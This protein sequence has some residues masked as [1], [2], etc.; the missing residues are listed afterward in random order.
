VTA[1][2]VV[3]GMT[4]YNNARHL[5][6]AADS[7]LAQTR[8]DFVLLMLDDGSADE[9]EVIAREYERRDARVRYIRH[10]ARCGMV[11][12]WRE[13]A[14]IAVRD[15]PEAPYFAWTSDHDRWHPEWLARLAA[16]L[17]AHPDVVLTYPHSP[18]I[19]E[20]GNPGAKE[21]REFDTVG[22]P[23]AA[24]RWRHF[25]HEGVG[26]GDMVYGLVRARALQAAGIFR[27]VLRP[28]RLLLAELTL[29]GHIQQVAEPLWFRRQAG[30]ASI[31]R[32]SRTLFAGAAPR[33]F[34]LPPWIQHAIVMLREYRGDRAPLRIPLGRLLGMVAL[35]QATYA[36]R[37][38][39]KSDTSHAIGRGVGNVIWSWKVAKRTY[40]H[41]VYYTLVEGRRVWGLARRHARRVTYEVLMAAHAARGRLRRLGRSVLHELLVLTHRLGLRG[42]T[43]TR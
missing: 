30:V 14:E 18:R 29:Q 16:V 34:W 39:R 13:V 42:G 38:V 6:E 43:G 26:A 5:R 3:L 32:Q 31:L 21:P 40:H 36:W 4:L 15:Y 12:T 2:K 22:L 25:C 19:D 27:P 7:L 37:H 28:D 11:P 8:N 1:P 9:T 41:A 10:Q 17:D 23:T 24:A 35:Y 33:W 20:A